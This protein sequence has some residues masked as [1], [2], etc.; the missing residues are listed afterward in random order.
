[1]IKPLWDVGTGNG[2]AKSLLDSA[3]DPCSAF[4][5]TVAIIRGKY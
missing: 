1:M 2:V 5:A 3:G 4:N